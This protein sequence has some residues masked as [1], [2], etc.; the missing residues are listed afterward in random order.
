MHTKRSVQ[1]T[2]MV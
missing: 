2:T 1:L